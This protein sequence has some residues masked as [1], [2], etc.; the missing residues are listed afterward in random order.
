MR[1]LKSKVENLTTKYLPRQKGDLMI[2]Y[3]VLQAYDD[4]YLA[5]V[6]IDNNNPL[7]RL[8]QWNLTWEWMRGEFIY[9]MR[10]AYTRKKDIS[11]CMYGAAGQYYK[12]F[13]FSKVMTCE[14]KPI[15]GD[16]P[17]AREKDKDIG[18][19]PNCCR[20]GTLLPTTMNETKSVSIFQL[21]VFKIPPD[22]NR[23]T[24]YPPERWKIVGVLNPQY[25]CGQI[26]RVDETEFPD[27]SGL[28]TTST[29]IA[30]WQVVC[31]ITRPKTGQAR[32]C[33]S[34]SAYY[35]D[36][37]VPCSACACGCENS[38][39]C[40]ANEQLFLP[41][42][43]LLVPFENRLEKAVN[44]AKI[45]HYK[46][47]KPMPCPDNCGVSI[48]WHVS[49]N[50]MKGWSA[51]ITLFNW[52]ET[53][54]A[55]WFVAVQLEKTG[56]GFEKA[57]SFNGTL[58]EDLNNTIFLTGLPGSNYLIGETN[59][60]NP[61]RDPR[62]PG[63]QQSVLMFTKK[64]LR[65]IR[66]AEGDVFP[67]RLFFNGEECALPTI[68]PKAHACCYPANFKIVAFIACMTFWLVMS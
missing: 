57:Y 49:S 8:D 59:G 7:G 14:K 60:T 68:F 12:D 39:K 10:G 24:L 17:P 55:D 5:Q 58:L 31:N 67:S 54:F 43:A 44:W 42:E 4:N 19:L 6:T 32:C 9:S 50:Y 18:N 34:Y 11:D 36:S 30:S 53:D 37:V 35:N 51:R 45:K 26:I 56:P 23:T 25:K 20:N 28:Q 48:N 16:L 52:I 62:V 46:I 40:N 15:I 22:L 2:T 41:P 47:P 13:D 64:E 29:A 38:K 27:T 61:D 3:D 65:G 1:D 66:V 21:Q 33:V 63:K